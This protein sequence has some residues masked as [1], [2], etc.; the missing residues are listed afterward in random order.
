MT[1]RR[2][3]RSPLPQACRY[4]LVA[5]ALSLGAV[6]RVLRLDIGRA[7]LGGGWSHGR[8]GRLIAIPGFLAAGPRQPER[9]GDRL[10]VDL[11]VGLIKRLDESPD[12]GW[13]ASSRFS[14]SSIT[15]SRSSERGPTSR[16]TM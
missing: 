14:S 2:P 3:V 5:Y 9:V 7:R 11:Y 15:R 16:V 1:L 10:G 4:A 12:H 13:S 6:S 8:R